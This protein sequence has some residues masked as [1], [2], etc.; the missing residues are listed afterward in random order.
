M[1]K[2]EVYNEI[3]DLFLKRNYIEEKEIG[4]VVD[5]IKHKAEDQF[6]TAVVNL[7]QDQIDKKERDALRDKVQRLTM[8]QETLYELF[9]TSLDILDSE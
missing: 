7:L 5:G 1:T 6:Y 2:Q 8:Q 3:Y 4:V 9:S